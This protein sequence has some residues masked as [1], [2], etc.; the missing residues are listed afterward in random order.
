[1]QA[2]PCAKCRGGA[3]CSAPT[4]A[5]PPLPACRRT[6]PCCRSCPARWWRVC[7]KRSWRRRPG[8]QRRTAAPLASWSTPSPQQQRCGCRCTGVRMQHP[9]GSTSRQAAGGHGGAQLPPCQSHGAPDLL[10]VSALPNPQQA[11]QD[12]G[13]RP[14]SEEQRQYTGVAI[15]AGM[16]CTADMADAGVLIVSPGLG[17]V[18]VMG[19]PC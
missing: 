9:A 10:V 12:A 1:M 16:S 14:E 15:G 7:L 2:Q 18:C 11:L 5:L 4:H 8:Q 17:V 3:H 19:V 13:W 6:G